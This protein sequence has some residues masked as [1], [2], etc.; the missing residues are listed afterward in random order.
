MQVVRRRAAV[1]CVS[2]FVFTLATTAKAATIALKWDASPEPAVVGYRVL[3]GEQPGTY[4]RAID[5]GNVTEYTL[6]GLE[7]DRRFYF[8]VRAYTAAGVESEPSSE[9]TTTFPSSPVV[10][11]TDFDGDGW[12]DLLWHHR[13]E[14]WLAVWRMQRGRLLGG[15]PLS[16]ARR[17]DPNWKIVSRA[18]F[19]VDGNP[20][21]LWQNLSTG[22]LEVWH[23]SAGTVLSVDPVR[24][25]TGDARWQVVATPDFNADGHPD[26]LWRHATEGWLAIWQM[27]GTAL[28]RGLPIEPSCIPDMNWTVAAATDF[29]GDAHPEILWHHRTEG[30]LTIWKLDGTRVTGPLPLSANANRVTD[31]N[32]R[33]AT[34]IDL[35]GDRHRD[36]LWQHRG[37]GS[38]AVWRMQGGTLLGGYPLIPNGVPD[39]NW[40]IAGAR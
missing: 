5:V 12:A 26:F 6:S 21:L 3:V 38:L 4:D 28:V 24:N 37:N 10:Q 27:N 25:D 8:A 16:V 2:A 9:V 19:D 11:D 17:A 20:D 39:L 18:D 36:I 7:P 15:V 22:E 34:V 32:W 30:W 23:M 35:D 1:L 40:L 31:T 33:I 14:G 13:T 29:D